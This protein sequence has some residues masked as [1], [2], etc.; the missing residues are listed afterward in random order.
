MAGERGVR[1]GPQDFH[2]Q[3][4]LFIQTAYLGDVIFSTALLGA[5]KERFR[6]EPLTLGAAW[7]HGWWR[8][9]FSQAAITHPA[10]DGLREEFST[11]WEVTRRSAVLLPRGMGALPPDASGVFPRSV[12]TKRKGQF[13]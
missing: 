3:R 7:P 4:I 12:W 10:N 8:S 9:Y 2:P 1:R 6:S 11:V 13:D 5:V